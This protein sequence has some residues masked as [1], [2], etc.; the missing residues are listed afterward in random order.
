MLSRVE[1]TTKSGSLLRLPLEDVE[2]GYILAS[3]DGLDPV[4]AT[5]VSS[6]FA[7]QDGEQYHSSR[8]EKRNLKM[9]L[10]YEP[11]YQTNSVTSLRNRL[12]S[13]LM[14]KSEVTLRF[15]HDDGLE[16]TILGRVE[17]F[18]APIFNKDPDASISLLSFDPDFIDPVP[19]SISGSTTESTTNPVIDYAG[20]VETG[21]VLTLAVNRAESA[22]TIYHI[23]PDG[24]MRQL[25]F[26]ASLLAGDEVKISTVSGDKY[27]TLKRA[28]VVS[29]VLYAIPPQSNWI[30]LEPEQGGTNNLRVYATGAPIPY[31]IEYFTRYGG[32]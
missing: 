32:L 21:I 4:K 29:K 7:N 24:T 9:N 31:T 15:V 1:V 16:V 30:Q 8:R 6:S 25:D 26:A 11:D 23:P 12:Y 17:S 10:D 19:V 27:A 13:F 3:V 22:F 14:P 2:N 28:G 20:T 5:I 18:D